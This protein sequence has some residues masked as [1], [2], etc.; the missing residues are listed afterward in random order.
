[1]A[2]PPPMVGNIVDFV[3]ANGA[4]TSPA[5]TDMWSSR[6]AS[7]RPIVAKPSTTT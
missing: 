3:F 2:S 4:L 1:V 6:V 7:P 5:P